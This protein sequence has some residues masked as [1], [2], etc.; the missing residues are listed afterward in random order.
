MTLKL[1]TSPQGKTHKMGR[2]RPV[3][4]GPRF[5]FGQFLRASLPPAPTS[6]D[7]TAP[8]RA[9]LDDVMLNDQLGDCVIAAGDHLVGLETSNC[10]TA[11]HATRDQIVADYSA[12][13]GYVL[14]DEST[15]QGCDEETAFA[16][17]QN[18]GF[19]NGTKLLGWLGV[20]PT[21]VEEIKSAMWLFENLFF[22]VELPDAWVDPFPSGSGFT[23]DAAGAAV[24]ENGHA[25]LG[26]G[27]STSGVLIDTWGMIGTV[28]Y[29]A[30]AKYCSRGVGGQLFVLLTSDQV[31]KGQAK[32]PN[33]VA[34]ADLV[35]A[36]DSIG[37]TVPVP[38]SPSPLPPAPTPAPPAPMPVV[39]SPTLEQS[40][41]AIRAAL[42]HAPS[43]MTRAHAIR[44]AD[45]ALA[46]IWKP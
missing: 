16:Y 21:N 27:H 1:L 33:G 26:V 32:A 28:T 31:A 11:F 44:V 20:D 35:V 43:V 34:W 5:Q 19:A 30:I 29:K 10:G 41:D 12:I 3:A 13:G 18:H 15:D 22:G 42:H 2:R 23:W 38:P 36:F 14:G 39:G 4:L 37:G 40:Q 17:W 9:V 45:A 7:Y 46:K 25:F 8:A 24:P 6:S